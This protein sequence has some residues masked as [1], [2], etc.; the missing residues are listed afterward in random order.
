M[1][2][3]AMPGASGQRQVPAR[4]PAD[5]RHLSLGKPEHRDECELILWT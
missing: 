4:A 1:I 5:V 2:N 3:T